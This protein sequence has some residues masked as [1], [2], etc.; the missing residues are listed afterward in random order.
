MISVCMATYNGERYIKEQVDSI[1]SQLGPDDEIVVSDDNSTD[2]TLSILQAYDDPRIKIFAHSCKGEGKRICDIVS[3]NFENALIHSSG[4][5]IFLS[6]QDDKWMAGK[7]EIMKK[8]L[9]N[10]AVVCS[11]AWL[12][13]SGDENDCKELLYSDRK[14]IKNYIMRRGKYYG[15]CMAFRQEC[16]KYVLPFPDPLPLHDTWLGLLPELVGGATFI[17]EP[18]IYYRQHGDNVSYNTHNPLYYKI[19]YRIR[20]LLLIYLRALKAKFFK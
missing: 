16:L 7:V 1:L 4:D 2:A 18:L 19:Y 9:Q 5:L 3:S 10:Y 13:R 15:C 12:W 6:D 14:P 17:D 20:I 8:E 11:N